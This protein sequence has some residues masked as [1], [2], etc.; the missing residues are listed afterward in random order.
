MWSWTGLP[1]LTQRRG[2]Y[3]LADLFNK[4][5][6]VGVLISQWWLLRLS[7][8]CYTISGQSSHITGNVVKLFDVVASTQLSFMVTIP[9]RFIIS[10]DVD[11][12]NSSVGFDLQVFRRSVPPINLGYLHV[13]TCEI[14][15]EK[16]ICLW[17]Y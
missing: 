7:Y 1:T 11:L 3:S 8:R 13:A 12:G 5:L 2:W 10:L 17:I 16:K 9:R 14:S 15:G 6:G 4:S